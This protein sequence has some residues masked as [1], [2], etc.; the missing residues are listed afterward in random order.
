MRDLLLEYFIPMYKFSEFVKQAAPIIKKE[1][2]SLLNVTVREIAKD[3]DTAL[4][5]AR[6]DMFGLVMLFTINRALEAENGISSMAGE[7]IELAYSMNGTF[8]LPYRNFA[9]PTQLR[10]CYPEF[11]EFLIKKK[12]FDPQEIFSSGFYQK[13]R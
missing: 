12:E 5:Y 4:P 7:L 3:I 6:Q 13:Y 10:K 11:S 1:Y 8:Y 2:D 9:T